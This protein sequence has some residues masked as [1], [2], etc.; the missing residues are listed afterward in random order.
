VMGQPAADMTKRRSACVSQLGCAAA[1]GYLVPGCL[2]AIAVDIGDD[3]RTVFFFV[4]Q[5]R[6]RWLGFRWKRGVG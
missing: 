3:G 4:R 6:Q 5:S 2:R 1:L